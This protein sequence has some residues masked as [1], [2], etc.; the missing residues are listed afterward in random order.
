MTDLRFEVFTE[1][2]VETL[3][4]RLVEFIFRNRKFTK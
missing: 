1:R 3:D 4:F 2:R